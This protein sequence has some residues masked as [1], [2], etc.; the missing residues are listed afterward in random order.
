[1]LVIFD[2]DGTI[3]DTQ[4]V[5]GRCY[6]LAIQRVTGLSISTAD[7]S[8]YDEPTSTAIVRQLLAGD[9]ELTE[10]EGQ[11]KSEF[12]D[13]LQ[14]ERSLFPGDFSSI[15]GALE[16]IARLR[17]DGTRV[18]IATGGF[19]TEARFKLECC[20]IALDT[21][22]HATSSDTSR[23]GDIIALAARR[24]GCEICSAVYFG[25]GP[26]DVRACTRLGIPMI[27]IG[28]RH[29]QL[30][31][32]GVQNTFRDYSEPER[33]VDALREIAL[34]SCVRSAQASPA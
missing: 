16:F 32:L 31:S 30:R 28:R 18:A 5:E 9:A 8:K 20:G 3:C 14:R 15:H 17:A 27:G 13:L 11:I 19:D 2:N 12:C 4:E 1:M 25:D 21:Y 26:W 6:A 10:K 7:W 23:R 33:I 34:R 22:P 24:A 29:E